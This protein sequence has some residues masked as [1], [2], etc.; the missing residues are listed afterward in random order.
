[1]AILRVG[2]VMGS[3]SDGPTMRK[4][5][6]ILD[7]LGVGY[8]LRVVSAHRTPDLLFEYAKSAADRGLHV[9]R[10]LSHQ[11]VSTASL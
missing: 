9:V 7:V 1:M 11:H 4:A 5:A 10:V 6:E 8:E 3:S 2:I